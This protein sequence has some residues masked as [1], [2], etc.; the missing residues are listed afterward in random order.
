[1]GLLGGVGKKDMPKL[2]N[3]PDTVPMN[4]EKAASKKM[5]DRF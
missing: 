5:G 2:G 1:M 4:T 3:I